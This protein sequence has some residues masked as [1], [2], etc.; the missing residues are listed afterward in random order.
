RPRSFKTLSGNSYKVKRQ[1]HRCNGDWPSPKPLNP[2]ETKV[3]N[4]GEEDSTKVHWQMV[5]YQEK[6]SGCGCCHD[7][8]KITNYSIPTLNPGS[9]WTKAGDRWGLNAGD[10]DGDGDN[11]YISTSDSSG[12]SCCNEISEE[13]YQCLTTEEL[14]AIENNCTI[15]SSTGY[16]SS[17]GGG[18]GYTEDEIDLMCRFKNDF[19][20]CCES[21]NGSPCNSSD[22]DNHITCQETCNQN[23]IDD[24]FITFGNQR[25][26]L[27]ENDNN[28]PSNPLTVNR[29]FPSE[30][31]G[32]DIDNFYP[33]L[34][35]WKNQ[36]LSLTLNNLWDGGT[37]SPC[38]DDYS[39][40]YK[41]DDFIPYHETDN[42]DCPHESVPGDYD[43]DGR[44]DPHRDADC[45]TV[46]DPADN[47]EQGVNDGWLECALIRK[48]KGL[49]DDTCNF[50]R[51]NIVPTTNLLYYDGSGNSN[52]VDLDLT[53]PEESAHDGGY[54]V[55]VCHNLAWINSLYGIVPD[56][57]CNDFNMTITK[58]VD[59]YYDWITEQVD[60]VANLSGNAFNWC[61]NLGETASAPSGCTWGDGV[62]DI[63]CIQ[64]CSTYAELD[65]AI[66]DSNIYYLNDLE[67]IELTGIEDEVSIT[68]ACVVNNKDICPVVRVGS[69]DRYGEE[70]KVRVSELPN[71]DNVFMSDLLVAEP[72]SVS[73]NSS[74]MRSMI[75]V[76]DTLEL[77][78]GVTD[79]YASILEG[80]QGAQNRIGS[81]NGSFPLIYIPEDSFHSHQD[82]S[83]TPD[84]QDWDFR[85]S[86]GSNPPRIRK[87]SYNSANQEYEMGGDGF[88]I[89]GINDADIIREGT[90]YAR[91]TFYAYAEEGRTPLQ[92]I[93]LDWLGNGSDVLELKGPFK[94]RKH[95][96]V[97]RCGSFYKDI[98]WDN[99]ENNACISGGNECI[100][101]V[102]DDDCAENFSCFAKTWGDT[103]D[104]C[105]GDS[106][107]ENSFL[108]YEH[109]YTCQPGSAYFHFDCSSHGIDGPPCCVYQ[110]VIKII[111]NWGEEFISES[112]KIIVTK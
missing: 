38:S 44:K 69:L 95:E 74:N 6:K 101:C 9:G 66:F 109:I 35:H 106:E 105:I 85:D 55:Y 60:M 59:T 97:R 99:N 15:V 61:D 41:N 63:G 26:I 40:D 70:V 3:H 64:T 32:L 68:E 49:K 2:P 75:A 48:L 54:G 89:N 42:P 110:P 37:A 80:L 24:F 30:L 111:D 22:L 5:Y 53:L 12:N 81:I 31:A 65:N 19:S 36:T 77:D 14:T 33:F 51:E 58:N 16:C 73:A 23:A 91:F 21:M 87:T 78:P 1:K 83:F 104:A 92:K 47:L 62:S 88:T 103:E 11:V 67:L 20:S 27:F 25:S 39:E 17:C 57:A 112:R 43:D 82:G 76:S 79:Y 98:L 4:L 84:P 34:S 46:V 71:S 72:F 7:K 50:I 56:Y 18:S 90:L 93:N 108:R 102:S 45:W 94:N 10:G 100:K 8:R 86:A 107:D 28:F 29:S 96:C 52:Y 13:V